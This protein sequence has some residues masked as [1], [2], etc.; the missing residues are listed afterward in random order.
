MIWSS[1]SFCYIEGDTFTN[2]EFLYKYKFPLQ[3]GN[4]SV[5]RASSVP[6]LS[7]NNQLQVILCQRGM[8]MCWHHRLILT[9]DSAVYAFLFFSFV[10]LWLIYVFIF[11]FIDIEYFCVWPYHNVFTHFESITSNAA[12]GSAILIHWSFCAGALINFTPSDG[13]TGLQDKCYFTVL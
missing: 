11:H 3:N 2:G 10:Y 6:S 1:F 7:Q 12:M 4:F 5:Y 8:F 9:T 13:F